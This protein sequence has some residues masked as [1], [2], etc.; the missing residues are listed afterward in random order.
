MISNDPDNKLLITRNSVYDI[1]YGI[2]ASRYIYPF[3]II[4]QCTVIYK[5][6]S[7]RIRNLPKQVRQCPRTLFN[8]EYKIENTNLISV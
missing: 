6:L 8:P 5:K 7:G 4:N 1:P 2:I 3:I